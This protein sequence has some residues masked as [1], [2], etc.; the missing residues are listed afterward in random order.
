MISGHV[1]KAQR[2]PSA[3]FCEQ[4]KVVETLA[5]AR[6][7]AARIVSEAEE[8]VQAQRAAFEQE[9]EDTRAEAMAAAED[10]VARFISDEKAGRMAE[11]LSDI[12]AFSN[13]LEADFNASEDWLTQLV[14]QAVRRVLSGLNSDE[15]ERELI[16][17]AIKECGARWKLEL[18]VSQEE[19]E[20]IERL[21]QLAGPDFDSIES[22][23]P[24]GS[25]RP[26]Q[27]LLLSASGVTDISL[28]VQLKTLTDVI[29]AACV[30]SKSQ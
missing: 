5:A 11:A 2:M 26:G 10:E 24:H 12:V 21:L 18:Q 17:S 4:Q 6:T 8:K 22:V 23:A 30:E 14:M 3:V 13:S 20:R 29:R 7:E 16:R 25:L 15:V 1:F 28:E 9:I 27:M 19:H